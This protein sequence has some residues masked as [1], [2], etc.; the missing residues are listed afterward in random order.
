MEAVP[1]GYEALFKELR[2]GLVSG[3]ENVVLREANVPVFLNSGFRKIA[4]IITLF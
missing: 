1:S 3:L 2:L 4:I